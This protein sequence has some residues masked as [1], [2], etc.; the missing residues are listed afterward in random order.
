MLAFGQW[1][2]PRTIF[3]IACIDFVGEQVCDALRMYL[4]FLIPRENRMRLKEASHIGLCLEPSSGEA[5]KRFL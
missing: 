5:L 2:V 1:H 4:A 3:V